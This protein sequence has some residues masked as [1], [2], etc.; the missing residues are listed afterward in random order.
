MHAIAREMAVTLGDLL[1]RRVPVA[2]ATRDH[3]RAIAARLAPAVG[4]RLGWTDAG[5]RSAL[6]EYDRECRAIFDIDP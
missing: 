6:D 2:F 3:G 5:Q 1:I 4:A